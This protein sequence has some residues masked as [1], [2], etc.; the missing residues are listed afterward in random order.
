MV[1]YV[2]ILRGHMLNTNI[3]TLL[4]DLALPRL[5]GSDAYEHIQNVIII[6]YLNTLFCK[7]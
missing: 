5:H 1:V 3:P 2:S 7:L 6:I 4:G